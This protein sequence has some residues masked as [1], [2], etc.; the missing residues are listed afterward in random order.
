MAYSVKKAY[1]KEEMYFAVP[2]WRGCGG[3]TDKPFTEV[4]REEW[5]WK[6]LI[7]MPEFVSFEVVEEAKQEVN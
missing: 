4:P 5:R 2:N 3:W 6:L 1:K 7:H